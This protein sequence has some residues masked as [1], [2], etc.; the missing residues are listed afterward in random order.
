MAAYCRPSKDDI[1]SVPTK[2][3]RLSRPWPLLREG[4]DPAS[5]E[6]R[7]AFHLHR[8]KLVGR[9]L[10]RVGYHSADAAD[11]AAARTILAPSDIAKLASHL[12][13]PPLDFTRQLSS[14]EHREWAFY[15]VSAANPDAV[16]RAARTA[17]VARNLTDKQAATLLGYTPK[18]LSK[19]I[20]THRPLQFPTAARLS[21]ALN[22]PG[23]PEALLPLPTHNNQEPSR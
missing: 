3:A 21:T 12:R 8:L 16:W 9:A 1:L 4:Q 11:L 5:L 14:D 23:G 6:A 19:A 17:W 13:I 2:A 20:R 22:I 10:H 15:R 7:V 18:S